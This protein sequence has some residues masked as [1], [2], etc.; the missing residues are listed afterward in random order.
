MKSD[1]SARTKVIAL[2]IILLALWVFIV[3]YY[4]TLSR[5]WKAKVAAQEQRHAAAAAS[6]PDRPATSQPSARIA[7]LVAPVPAPGS[8]PFRPVISPR[9][10]SSA[11]R[12]GAPPD[13]AVPLL[14]PPPTVP[15]TRDR[16]HVTGI[17]VGNPSAAVLRLG[18]EHYVVREGYVLDNNVRVDSIGES[19]VTLRDSRGTYILRLGR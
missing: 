11:S 3:V 16:L 9:T 18:E 5:H 12:P 4:V 7:A 17:I 6:A 19:S 8:D 10:R 1:K 14:P 2:S 15:S 13:T